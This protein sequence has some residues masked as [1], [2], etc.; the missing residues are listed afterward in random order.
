VRPALV[1]PK[2]AL[3]LIRVYRIPF[4]TNVERVALAAGHKG[5]AIEWVD[6]DPSDR[7]LVED[8]SGQQLV[9]MLVEGDE[10]VSDSPV[11]VDWLERRFPEPPLYPRE[12]PRRAE[13]RVFVDW[14]NNVWKRPP[15]LIAAEEEQS[16][17]D[18]ARIAELAARMRTYI[19]LFEDL[20]DGRDYLF[21]E[22]CAADVFAF[23]F[24]KYAAFG[25]P[26]GD[27]ERFHHILVEHQPLD[28]G[29]PL[30]AWAERVDAH[31]RS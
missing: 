11:I 14:F 31:P 17:P 19:P 16:E 30:H 2:E 24:L 22:F 26:A 4:S 6:V 9:P 20:L 28:A 25:T 13:V 29:S 10:I 3:D 1:L 5:V 15:N 7:S 23:P 27:E 21:G 8:V 12:A 18:A